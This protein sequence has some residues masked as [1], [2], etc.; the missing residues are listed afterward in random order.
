VDR[1]LTIGLFFVSLFIV[2]IAAFYLGGALTTP[3]TIIPATSDAILAEAKRRIPAPTLPPKPAG[4]VVVET[5]IIQQSVQVPVVKFQKGPLGI[6]I[7]V[8]TVQTQQTQQE[9]PVPKL[10]DASPEETAAWQAKVK[11]LQDQYDTALQN[12]IKRISR[13]EELSNAKEVAAFIKQLIT[14][15]IVPIVLAL[16]GLVGAIVSLVQAFKSKPKNDVPA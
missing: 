3:R 6:N 13:E 7:P 14:D 12:E 8:A 4:H 5:K 1:K 10:V 16:A 11:I 2:G 15:V 9:V